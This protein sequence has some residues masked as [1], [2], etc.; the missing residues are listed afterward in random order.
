MFRSPRKSES[1]HVSHLS[2][3][4]PAIT[5]TAG[6]RFWFHGLRNSVITVAEREP[7]LPRSLTKRPV[8]HARPPDATEGCA[9]DWTVERLREPAQRIAGKIDEL[10]Q[11]GS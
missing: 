3:F 1:G 4:Y 5:G 2:R 6:T 7:M 9:A 8:D 10:I 11:S